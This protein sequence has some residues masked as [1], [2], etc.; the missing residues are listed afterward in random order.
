[1][2]DES[3][4]P[5]GEPAPLPEPLPEPEA[6]VDPDRFNVGPSRLSSPAEALSVAVG[7][8]LAT[9]IVIAFAFDPAR[10]GTRAVLIALGLFYVVIGAFAIRRLDQRGELRS[11]FRPASGDFALGAA[12]AGGLFGIAHLVDQVLAPHGSIR[13][14]WIIR[15]YLQIGDPN[16]P[17]HVLVG[18]AVFLIAAVEELVWRGLVM[19]TLE[20]VYGART[21]LIVTA[22]LYAVA[23]APTLYLLADPAAGLNPLVV[24]AALGCG[25]VWGLVYLR[26]ERLVP[27]LFAHA[28]FSWAVVEFPIWRP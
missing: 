3:D 7:V 21:A 4:A 8:T 10:A 12:V 6:D 16:A 11:R 27:A 24:L 5:A 2:S 1:M 9:G 25:L 23:H 14:A 26:T 28:L 18:G 15:V 17:G 20:A 13:E 19:R 22:V